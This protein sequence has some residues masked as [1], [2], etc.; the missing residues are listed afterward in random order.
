MNTVLCGVNSIV[1][2]CIESVSTES[3]T[4]DG[5]KIATSSSSG[6]IK[7]DQVKNTPNHKSYTD[8]QQYATQINDHAVVQAFLPAY[9]D[10]HLNATTN[11][12]LC[13]PQRHLATG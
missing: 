7:R 13:R 2:F 1:Y 6:N 10:R 11:V 9:M 5:Y 3:N 12:N 8:V 4:T